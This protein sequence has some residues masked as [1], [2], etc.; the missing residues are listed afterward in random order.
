MLDSN[1]S[2]AYTHFMKKDRLQH[3]VAS[4]LDFWERIK[5]FRNHDVILILYVGGC[6]AE[7]IM[8]IWTFNPHLL[9]CSGASKLIVLSLAF[10]IPLIGI[11]SGFFSLVSVLEVHDEEI[12]WRL[13]TLPIGLLSSFVLFGV[14]LLVSNLF[15]VKFRLFL[16]IVVILEILY[17]LACVYFARIS[18]KGPKPSPNALEPTATAPSVSTN[19]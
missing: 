10:T 8:A 5:A 11:N 17:C 13:H 16:I 19:K 12:R 4:I 9:E 1:F 7:G 3:N 14:P 6:V 18:K 15:V 2:P